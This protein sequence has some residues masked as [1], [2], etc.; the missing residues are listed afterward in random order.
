VGD[1][2]VGNNFWNSIQKQIEQIE[3]LEK[4]RKSKKTADEKLYNEASFLF[5]NSSLLYN[6]FWG[7]NGSEY[8][9]VLSG[10]P[11]WKGVDTFLKSTVSFEFIE[12]VRRGYDNHNTLLKSLKLF[13]KIVQDY[14]QSKLKEK[15]AY[16]VALTYYYLSTEGWNTPLRQK[17]SWDDLA[18][19]AFYDFVNQFP[20]SS[21]ADDALLSIATLT[22]EEQV[23]E[24]LIKDYPKGDRRR[25]AEKMLR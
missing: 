13:K 18:I 1:R 9:S 5:Y 4:I 14:P 25:E 22:L 19:K 16:S 23:V 17:D 15:A 12:E 7:R 3:Q 20:K 21:M 2:Y 24:K 11:K 8:F 6:L 10:T